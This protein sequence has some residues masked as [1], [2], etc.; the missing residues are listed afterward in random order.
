M[1]KAIVNKIADMPQNCSSSSLESE[2]TDFVLSNMSDH[3]Y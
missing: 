1:P 2:N 3:S